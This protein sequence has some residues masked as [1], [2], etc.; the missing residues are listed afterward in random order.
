MVGAVA[1]AVVKANAMIQRHNSDATAREV[2]F[3]GVPV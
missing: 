3:G 1:D 2:R